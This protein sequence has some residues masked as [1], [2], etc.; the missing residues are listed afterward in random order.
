MQ[1]L[2][3]QGKVRVI[4]LSFRNGGPGEEL[5]PAGFGYRDIKE[6]MA[7]GVF[8]VLQTVYGG[9]TRLNEMAIARAAQAGIGMIIRGVVKNYEENYDDL[10]AQANLPELGDPGE[11]QS[12]FLIRF[13]LNHPGLSTMIIGSKSA[14][15]IAAN[16]QAAQKGKLSDDVY[17]EA[18]RRLD[19]IGITAGTV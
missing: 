14:D 9:L 6:F 19:A 4:G 16:V 15:H 18:K 3:Q 2:K 13:A 1:E 5:Y 7:W 11:T 12:S 10:F 8:D 17:R